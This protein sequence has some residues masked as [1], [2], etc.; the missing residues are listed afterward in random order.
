[1][2]KP[3]NPLEE[4]LPCKAANESEDER[5][6]LQLLDKAIAKLQPCERIIID[7]FFRQSLSAQEVAS[8]L[9]L[10]VGAVCTQKSR[11]LAK[12]REALKKSGPL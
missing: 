1:L 9:H 6:Q 11:I 2:N 10:S 12:L 7:L 8:I 4:S 3:A 5:S